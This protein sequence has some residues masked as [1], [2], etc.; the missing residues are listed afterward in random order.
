[1]VAAAAHAGCVGDPY[2]KCAVEVEVPVTEQLETPGGGTSKEHGKQDQ[3]Q[4]RGVLGPLF[5]PN[6]MCVYDWFTTL[7]STRAQS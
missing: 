4:I 6:G 3:P 5:T 1:M 2:L 7:A